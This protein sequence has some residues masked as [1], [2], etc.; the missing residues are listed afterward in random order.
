MTGS[1]GAAG[2][3][4]RAGESGDAPALARLQCAAWRRAYAE[5]LP[6]E[7]LD[8]FAPERRLPLWKSLLASP[9]SAIVQVA[10]QP[11]EA[12][13]GVIWMRRTAVAGATYAAEIIAI[14]VDPD[15]QGRGVGRCLMAAAAEVLSALELPDVYLWVYRDNHR[16]RGFYEALGGRLVDQ[17]HERYRD[18]SLP[19]VAYAWK[20]LSELR[21]GLRRRDTGTTS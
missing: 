13:C 12:P 6:A 10:L 21:A 2:L 18:L 8:E 5:L 20:P 14:A 19:I 9:E 1:R 11:D 16:A 17:D 7:V 4:V 3:I 15:R